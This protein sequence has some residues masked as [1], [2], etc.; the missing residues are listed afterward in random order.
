[1]TELVALYRRIHRERMAGLPFLNPALEVE[2]L[3]FQLRA[4]R[5]SGLLITPW[6]INFVLFPLTPDEWAG[7]TPGTRCRFPLER[8]E[9]EL[10]HDFEPAVGH[11][12]MCTLLAP[13]SHLADQASARTTALAALERLLATPAAAAAARAISASQPK[14]GAAVSRRGFL[15]DLLGH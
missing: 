11:Y 14:K 2:T 4:G 10:I 7:V 6:F 13:V 8:H 15:R 1:M 3:Q 5:W 9:I 12:R